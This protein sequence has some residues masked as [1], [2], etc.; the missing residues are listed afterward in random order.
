MG[1]LGVALGLSFCSD[2][3]P[4]SALIQNGNPALGPKD[5]QL[6]FS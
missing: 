3:F 6:V 4:V 5:T 2:E 1:S